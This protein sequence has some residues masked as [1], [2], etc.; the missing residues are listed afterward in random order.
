MHG[1]GLPLSRSQ[2][3]ELYLKLQEKIHL[4]DILRRCE[5]DKESSE[6]ELNR[7]KGN[8]VQLKDAL[9]KLQSLNESL[10]QEKVQISLA[11]TP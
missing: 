1:R 7:L 9:V 4:N 2:N 10:G 11:A 6:T 3:V 5:S 8:E